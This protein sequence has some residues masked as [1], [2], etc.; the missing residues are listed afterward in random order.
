VVVVSRELGY[1]PLMLTP[2][3]GPTHAPYEWRSIPAR[4][5]RLCMHNQQQ[6]LPTRACKAART[7]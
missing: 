1:P 3:A 4:P 5:C 6:L 2:P 7:V